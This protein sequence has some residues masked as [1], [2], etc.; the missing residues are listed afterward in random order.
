MNRKNRSTEKLVLEFEDR[1]EIKNLMA[2]YITALMLNRDADLFEQFWSM[3]ED[4]CIAFNDGWYLGKDAVAGY[5]QALGKKLRLI[6]K[7]LQKRFPEQLGDKSF[8]ELYGIG[9][10]EAKPVTNPYVVV[11]ND[12]NTARGVWMV[13]GADTEVGIYGPL[14][15]WTWGVYACDFIQE[16]GA[17][18]LLH[19]QYLEDIRHIM[20]QNWSEPEQMPPE[21]PEFAALKNFRLPAYT[22]SMENRAYYTPDRPFAPLPKLPVPYETMDPANSYGFREEAGANA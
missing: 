22:V 14:S 20:G 8:E 13:Q 17:W 9:P 6:A 19:M 16:D 5:Y 4:V 21:L 7:L 11:A 1:R 3:Q 2:K 15:Y 10:F 12:R 18:K